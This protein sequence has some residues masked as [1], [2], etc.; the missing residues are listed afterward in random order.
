MRRIYKKLINIGVTRLSD[1]LARK[2]VMLTNLLGF[3]ATV[4]YLFFI[5]TSF[6]LH[7]VFILAAASVMVLIT[8]AGFVFNYK[9][10]A[11]VSKT[12]FIV[13]S[14]T[15]L[16]FTYNSF[17]IS[18][19]ILLFYYPIFLAHAMFY[20]ARKEKTILLLNIGYTL[21]TLTAALLL[22][23]HLLI[24]IELSG[25]GLQM[26]NV[27]N[28][29]ASTVMSVAYIYIIININFRMEQKFVKAW[30]KA[31]ETSLVL[32]EAKQKAETASEVK[33]RFLSNMSHELRT[34]LNGIIGTT[35]L[36]LCE[37]ATPEQKEHFQVL[38]HCS[39]YMLGLINDI[40]DLN[41]LE[42]KKLML[43]H[44]PADIRLLMNELYLSFQPQFVNKGLQF[45]VF[46]DPG[47]AACYK[48]D[49]LRLTQV[50][51]NLISN[52]LKFTPSGTVA[53]SVKL[54]DTKTD[55][56]THHLIF[57]VCDTGI[58]IPDESQTIIFE[59]FT[60]ADSAT[61]RM[62]GGS[63]LGLSISRH[64]VSLMNGVL[65]VKSESGKGSVFSFSVP[66][67]VCSGLEKQK[68]LPPALSADLKALKILL[69][70]DNKVNSAVAERHL[71]KL[72]LEVTVAQNGREALNLFRREKYD[73]LLIDLEM[74]VLDGYALIRKI[75]ETG[76]DTPAVAFT[77]TVFENMYEKLQK[78][79]FNSYLLKPFRPEDLKHIITKSVSN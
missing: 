66:L 22:P 16:L 20:E 77:A 41:K 55:D 62:Y 36:L 63:G 18:E 1:P 27:F 13:S 56:I 8:V 59:N 32:K 44:K 34:P 73:L 74:P 14:S 60:Q 46:T 7:S 5:L 3:Y 9:G 76:D 68:E 48:A 29:I 19:T 67:A 78:A 47:L 45:R 31:K 54:L 57:E 21:A 70:E 51:N 15:I 71:Q 30:K 10:Y 11:F 40:L 65:A 23:R 35:N 39:E 43:E 17:N 50:L 4:L 6:F 64:L 38:Q 72:G 58:G 33:S 12:L 61:T 52:A 24:R 28:V 75:R 53:L 69:A 2:R 42:A 79:G 49:R 25:E 26:L 37:P